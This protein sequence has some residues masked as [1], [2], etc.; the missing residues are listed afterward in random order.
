MNETL[1]AI[2]FASTLPMSIIIVG[3]GAY[4]SAI[5]TKQVGIPVPISM[6][7]GAAIA[8]LVAFILSF[9]LFR[10]KAF[11]FLIGSFAAGEVI[12]SLD[13]RPAVAANGPDNLGVLGM[14]TS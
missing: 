7:L 6:L 11:Y 3:V 10:M 14:T 8:G 1:A 9:P 12:L 5:L 13:G 2:V 4:G